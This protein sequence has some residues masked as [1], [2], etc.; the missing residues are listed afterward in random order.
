MKISH[1]CGWVISIAMIVFGS[2]FHVP[3]KHLRVSSYSYDV[4]WN[5]LYGEE[6][7]GGDAYNY[8]ME[9]SLKAGYMGG[10]MT[11]KTLC[12][13][14]GILLLFLTVYSAERNH[15][16]ERQTKLLAKLIKGDKVI[17]ETEK[18]QPAPANRENG[19]G[20]G[21]DMFSAIL[22]DEES[23]VGK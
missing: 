11:M 12:V 6:Y 17:E 4:G 22:G 16:I 14:S 9:A 21:Q 19:T 18:K 10:V 8:Q 1:V 23:S 2:A 3:E 13:V 5:E 15:A 7:V 20:I